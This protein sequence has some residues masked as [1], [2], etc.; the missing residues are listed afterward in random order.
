VSPIVGHEGSLTIDR[1]HW[2]C[3]IGARHRAPDRVRARV[4]DVVR[5]DLQPALIRALTPIVDDGTDAVWFVRRIAVELT[6]D[7]RAVDERV[8]ADVWSRRVAATLAR[9]LASGG[10]G[11]SVVRFTN[12]SEFLASFL[13]DLTAGRAWDRWW[14]DEMSGLRSLPASAAIREALVRTPERVVPTL[15]ALLHA[16]ALAPVIAALTS[17]DARRVLTVASGTVAS[18]PA[19]VSPRAVRDAIRR[20]LP[21]VDLADDPERAALRLAVEGWGMGGDVALGAGEGAV[22][23]IAVACARARNDVAILDRALRDLPASIEHTNDAMQ[24]IAQLARGDP[25]WAAELLETIDVSTTVREK[26]STALHVTAF[27][28]VWLLVPALEA[29]R[30]EEVFV[31]AADPRYEAA[32]A[33]H[34]IL[35]KCLGARVTPVAWRDPVVGLAAG[36]DEPPPLD[37]LRD[38]T[39]AA[40]WREPRRREQ[41]LANAREMLATAGAPARRITAAD[42]SHLSLARASMRSRGVQIDP[43]VDRSF[44][45]IARAVMRRFAR[46][47]SGFAES[48]IAYLAGN[49]L[50]GSGTLEVG[51]DEEWRAELPHSPLAIVL[52][53]AGTHERVLSPSWYEGRRIILTLPSG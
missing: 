26:T 12:E 23:T 36:L 41:V 33:R 28:G 22:L 16:R 13:I 53:M 8:L 3:L 40:L 20:L 31:D 47:L 35:V 4:E 18:P 5:H 9:A 48:G 44:T 52:R 46:T 19:V 6:A 24:R 7:V 25:L 10:D 30:L 49:F 37:V 32:I 45:I 27:A 21:L 38:A 34:V 50:L 11:E 14:Y 29:L 51:A 42:A 1:L 43:L 15:L 39:R 17:G 2:R